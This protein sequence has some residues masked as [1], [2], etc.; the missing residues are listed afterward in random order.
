MKSKFLAFSYLMVK[1]VIQQKRQTTYFQNGVS[2]LIFNYLFH[3]CFF[4]IY[5]YWKFICY[6]LIGMNNNFL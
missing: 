3:E 5:N 1:Y 4:D 2:I 6:F